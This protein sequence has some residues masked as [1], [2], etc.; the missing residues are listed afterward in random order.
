MKIINYESKY[1]DTLAEMFEDFHNI[2]VSCDPSG[3]VKQFSKKEYVFKYVDKMINDSKKMNGFI[4]LAI[5]K[6][7]PVGF[8][9]GVIFDH[10]KDD[11][12]KLVSKPGSQGWIGELYV[13]SLFRKQG[14]GKLLFDKAKEYFADNNCT[15]IRLNVFDGNKGAMK[16]YNELGMMTRQHEMELKL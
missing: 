16:L 7:K 14:I 11:M 3:M 9:Q 10:K 6:N 1:K 4:F 8:V 12:H 15:T 5:V 2:M 13:E